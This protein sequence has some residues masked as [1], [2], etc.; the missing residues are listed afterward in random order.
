MPVH[1]YASMFSKLFTGVKITDLGDDGSGNNTRSVR[2]TISPR[3]RNE[4]NM[5]HG[6]AV[7]LRSG[8]SQCR[9]TGHD[10]LDIGTG[11]FTNTNY[12][13]DPSS[14]PDPTVETND[15]GG[16]R[17]FYTSTDQDGNF[18]VGGL[19]NV[20]Q[21]T[22]IAT[23]N[24]EAFNISGLNELQLG[25]VALGGAGAV[26]NEFSTDGTFSADSDSVVPTQKAIKT[27]ITSQIGGGV[28][29]LNVNSVTA[30]VIEIT[31]NQISTTSGGKININNVVNFK[32]GIDG[33][34]V[35]LQMF[36]LN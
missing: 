5:L 33:A 19:F 32:G 11:N 22:G 1:W 34:P 24:V 27:Y 13:G 17:V 12:P 15:F 9:I 29:T 16:G 14:L 36:L 30:G 35:A 18:R 21:A 26:I 28:A 10:F 3:L 20:E 2:F 6:T 8:Y 31:Q 4:N 7:T 23:L 25:S